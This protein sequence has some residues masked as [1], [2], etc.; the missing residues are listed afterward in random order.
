[1]VRLRDR[2]RESE[3]RQPT[4]VETFSDADAFLDSI[5]TA[6][7]GERSNLERMYEFA[8]SLEEEGLASL[9]TSVTERKATLR[10]RLPKQSFSLV[11]V[12]KHG[13]Y[14]NLQ[15]STRQIE[16]YAP[17][18][19]GRLNAIRTIESGTRYYGSLPDSFLKVLR[20]AY[21]EACETLSYED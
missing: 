10:V 17:K 19:K 11:N 12:V 7:P 1:M 4:Q 18:A 15:F 6:R 21:S 9:S 5:Q 13:S 14:C 20:D 3:L 16:W 8:T 2:D